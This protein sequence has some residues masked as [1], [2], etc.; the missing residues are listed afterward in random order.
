MPTCY[1]IHPTAVPVPALYPPPHSHTRYCISLAARMRHGCRGP[2]THVRRDIDG[3]G[4]RNAREGAARGVHS[5]V[6]AGIVALAQPADIGQHLVG[7]LHEAQITFG[8]GALFFLPW[9][10]VLPSLVL[11]FGLPLTEGALD[12]LR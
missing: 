11:E 8:L 5:D 7:A 6:F 12:L 10:S 9:S 1:Y 4:P 3:R 2:V